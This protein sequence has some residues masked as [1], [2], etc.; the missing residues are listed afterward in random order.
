[1][2]GTVARDSVTIA[3]EIA[4][5][6]APPSIVAVH[7]TGMCKEPWRPVLAA[8]DAPA[9]MFDQRGHGASTVGP[10]PFNW[11]D[12]A[13]DALAVIDEVGLERPFVGVGH[14]SGAAVLAMAEIERPG[15]FSSLVLIEPIV[16]PGPYERAEEAPLAVG[17]MRRRDEFASVEEFFD[18]FR[19]RGPFADW[20]DEALL[21]YAEH[22]TVAVDGGGRRLACRP[23]VEAEYYRSATAHAAWDRLGE[24]GCP[25]T[26]V[27]GE[28][29]DT[30]GADFAQQQTDQFTTATLII[31]PDATHFVPMEQPHAVATIVTDVLE[32]LT[33]IS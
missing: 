19:G 13:G 29:S 10:P 23:E 4:G 32:E 8:V 31:V 6:A 14:S 17:A 30:H 11:W 12:G 25:V 21:A 33:A 2:T 22:G 9:V 16:F 15:T 24:I 28:A 5:G 3:Y 7:A 1:M 18:W 27:A 20:V 26:V